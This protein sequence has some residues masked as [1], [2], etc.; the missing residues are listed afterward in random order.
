MIRLQERFG[1]FDFEAPIGLHAPSSM[2]TQGVEGTAKKQNK[3]KPRQ[4]GVYESAAD[5]RD[6]L[7]LLAT[8][9]R[10]PSGVQKRQAIP[11]WVGAQAQAAKNGACV[12]AGCPPA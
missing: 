2:A 12:C 1:K 3:Q 8:W 7:S 6:G 4:E 10:N 9:I 5:V 11:R